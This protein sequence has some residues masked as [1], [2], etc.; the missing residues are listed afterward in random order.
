MSASKECRDVVNL[1][2][3]RAAVHQLV[4][5]AAEVELFTI[6]LYMTALYSI[7][8]LYPAPTQGPNLWPG[9][10]PNSNLSNPNQ[11]TYNA[12]FSVY[13]Q[14][15]LH[16]QLASNLCTAVGLAP[17]FPAL[18]YTSFGSTIP[19]IGDLKNVQGYE[20]VEVKLGPLDL[21]QIK[22]FLAIEMPDWEANADSHTRPSVPFPTGN[23]GKATIPATFGAIGHLYYCIEAY[24]DI[25][26]NDGTTLWDNIYDPNSIQVDLFNF[27]SKSAGHPDKEY[28]KFHVTFP[29]G[30]TKKEA[31]KTA[32]EIITAIIDQGEGAIVSSTVPNRFVPADEKVAKDRGKDDAAVRSHWDK[33]SHYDRFALVRSW[34]DEVQTWPQWI[35][36]RKNPWTAED[37]LVDPSV[38]TP[39]ELAGA[40]A[41]ASAMNDPSTAGQINEALSHS[42]SNIL[43][44]MEGAWA[45][46]TATFPTAAMQALY[47]RVATIWATGGVPEFAVVKPVDILPNEGHAC[48]GLDPKNPGLNNCANAVPHTCSGANSCKNQGGCGY[49]PSETLPD[50]NTKAGDGGCGAPIPDAQVFHSAA[51][52]VTVNSTPVSGAEGRSVYDTAWEVFVAQLPSAQ[53]PAKPAPNNLRI[54]LPPS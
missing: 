42:Y 24:F 22:L 28:P 1:P 38:A 44:A 29:A 35:A 52:P 30:Q 8:G 15:M 32:K 41:R 16:L 48:Q 54:V 11:Y 21:N 14:E 36:D 51:G 23:D 25:K 39:S 49:P 34:I 33:Q 26:Y 2:T 18:D 47:T 6:P 3:D 31:R 37:L 12:I 13:I 4:Q 5:L 46:S 10:R 50:F 53:P 17:K 19:C 27:K 40:T 43:V 20:D 9:V 45:N 7:R